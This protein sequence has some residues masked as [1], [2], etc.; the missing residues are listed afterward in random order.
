VS[1]IYATRRPRISV[2]KLA[3]EVSDS[4]AA[5]LIFSG[6]VPVGQLLPGETKLAARYGV[7]R[8]T[9]RSALR[10]LQD[11][12]LIR[13]R[14]GIGS[15]VLPRSPAVTKGLDQL[16]SL[17]TYVRDANH[18]VETSD[19]E[20]L[21]ETA[22]E[23][24]AERLGIE[25]G[26]PVVAAHRVKL[27]DGAR[28][29][30]GIERVPADLLPRATLEAEYVGSIM[31]VLLAHP[32][33]GIEYADAEVAPV[34]LPRDVASRLGVRTGTVAQFLEQVMYSADDVPVQWGQAWLLPEY[35][36]FRMRRRKPV[37]P[38]DHR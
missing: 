13:I 7:S 8:V 35:Y 21:E 34:A 9:L 36:R 20:W 16:C 14:N 28:T 37:A 22:D 27:I 15:V 30:W 33:L 6:Q 12:S 10:L 5:E 29:S 2:R 1:E 25:V 3:D 38:P 23:L 24:A 31:D 32:E 26:T 4:I 11:A 18:A 17:E 19:L